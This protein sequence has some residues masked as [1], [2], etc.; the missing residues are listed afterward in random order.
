MNLKTCIVIVGP[1]AVGKT[2]LSLELARQFSTS[3]ISADSRQ[4]FKELNIGVA[5][6]S[7]AELAEVKH[8]FINSHHINEEV[9]AALFEKLAIAWCNQIFEQKDIAIIVGGTGLYVK[10]FIE[11]LD[12]MPPS[13]SQTRNQILAA[14]NAHGIQWLQQKLKE[15]DPAFFE[16]G[17][18]HNPQRMLRALEVVLTSGRSILS[19]QSNK[20]RERPFNILKIGLDLPRPVLYQRINSRV[21]EMLASGLVEEARSLIP[22]RH[23]NS[24]QTVGYRELFEQLDGKLPME[25]CIELIKQNSRHYAK[26]QLTWFRKDDTIHWFDAFK[27]ASSTAF[28]NEWLTAFID[29]D[30]GKFE[31]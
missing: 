25:K 2:N 18:I 24:L 7:P 10:A 20:K 5:K 28:V 19:F 1:T 14:Y 4:C 17:E 27:T 16:S 31:R 23:L 29:P 22:Y 30:Q 15:S 6:P 11:G 3:I 9:N 21:D 12:E 8:F 13:S 26:R